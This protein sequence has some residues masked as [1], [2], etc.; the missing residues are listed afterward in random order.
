MRH[1]EGK[2]AI[3]KIFANVKMTEEEQKKLKEFEA[4]IEKEKL[5]FPAE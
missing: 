5:E 3:R 4:L 2:K 1:G